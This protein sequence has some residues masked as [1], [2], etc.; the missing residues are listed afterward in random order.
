MLSTQHGEL[1]TM[2]KETIDTTNVIDQEEVLRPKMVTVE[3]AG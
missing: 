2:A 3:I 1:F